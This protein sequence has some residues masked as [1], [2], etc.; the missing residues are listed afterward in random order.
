MA[1]WHALL[2]LFALLLVHQPAELVAAVAVV[3]VIA[4]LVGVVPV[5]P[6]GPVWVRSLA[7]RNRAQRAAFL[8]LRDPDAAGRPRPRAPGRLG[9]SAA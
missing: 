7:L 8:R 4:L 9:S 2:A 5:G 6:T 3:A 1:G